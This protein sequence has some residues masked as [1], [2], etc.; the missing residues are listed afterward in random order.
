MISSDETIKDIL[1]EAIDKAKEDFQQM[2]NDNSFDDTRLFE[3]TFLVKYDKEIIANLIEKLT[4]SDKAKE[5]FYYIVKQYSLN[6]IVIIKFLI[7]NANLKFNSD[8]NFSNNK[9]RF[10]KQV[11]GLKQKFND[12]QKYSSEQDYR[13]LPRRDLDC[14][15]GFREFLSRYNLCSDEEIRVILSLLGY[16]KLPKKPT[17]WNAI[18]R[19]WRENIIKSL[20]EFQKSHKDKI[21]GLSDDEAKEYSKEFF[22]TI[23]RANQHKPK[24]L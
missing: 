8:E 20:K 14:L 1:L 19:E 18:N 12:L 9:P 16:E 22:K 15:Y 11:S 23:K 13:D 7:L 4:L 21:Y 10:D 24:K 6:A 17:E 5:D 3:I 2:C